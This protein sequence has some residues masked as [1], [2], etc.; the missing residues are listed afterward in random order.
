MVCV[1]LVAFV[2]LKIGREEFKVLIETQNKN[3]K[4]RNYCHNDAQNAKNCVLTGRS[5]D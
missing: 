4:R 1:E 5:V 2:L 3:A